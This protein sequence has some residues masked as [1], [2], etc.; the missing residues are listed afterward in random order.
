MNEL[1]RT[2]TAWRRRLSPDELGL[3][4]AARRRAAGLRREEVAALASVST[5]YLVR[6]E[7][8]RAAQPSPQVV[9]ALA[10]ALRLT[11]AEHEHLL[12]LAGHSPPGPRSMRRHMPPT[13]QRIADRLDDLPLHVFDAAWTLQSSNRLGMALSGDWSAMPWR[14]RNLVHRQFTGIPSRVAR[15]HEQTEAYEIGL[16]ADLQTAAA[17][18]PEDQQIAALITELSADSHRF[19]ELWDQRNAAPLQS[20]RKVIDHP[21]SGRIELDCDAVRADGTDLILVV[22]SAPPST[23][24]AQALELL[25]VVGR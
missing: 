8:G 15:D 6:I 18:W 3:P 5:D 1:G 10:R 19:A 23:A 9:G 25:R 16:V 12:R 13:L 2:L 20:E 11:D 4:T 7:Q 22:Y 24:A 17:R 21:S 14:E